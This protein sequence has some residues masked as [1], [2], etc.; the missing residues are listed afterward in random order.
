MTY[1]DL[2]VCNLAIDRVSGDRLDFMGEETPLGAFCADNYPH[3]RDYI[4]GKYRWTFANRVALMAQIAADPAEARPLR[5]KFAKPAD[6]VGAVHDWRDTADPKAKSVTAYVI[7]AND[8]FWS[9]QTPLFAEY[10]AQ[11]AEASWPAWFRQL[12]VTAFA[13][14]LADHCQRSTLARELRAEAWGTPQE[15]GEGGLY[16]AAR[17]EDARHAPQR[18]LVSGVDPGPLVG[19][20]GGVAGFAYRG[21]VLEGG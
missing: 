6:L 1:T 12:V 3:K 13:A 14:D 16:A 18:H 19:V 10:T 2:S 17:N 4:L 9:D 15:N 11:K 5:A 20:R 7:E 8:G 21:F